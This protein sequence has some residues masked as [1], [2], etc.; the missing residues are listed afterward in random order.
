MPRFYF[1]TR[2][3]ETFLPDDDGVELVSVEAARDEATSTL[4]EM[5]KDALPD[6]VGRER[7][8]EVR[9]EAGRPLFRAAL[10]LGIEEVA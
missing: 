2:D 8:I 4:A 7:A 1:D 5:L 6:D 10:F 9:D 3:G